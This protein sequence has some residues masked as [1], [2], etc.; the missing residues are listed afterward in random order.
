VTSVQAGYVGTDDAQ[1]AR[2]E[3]LAERLGQGRLTAELVYARWGA[4][5]QRTQLDLAAPLIGRLAELAEG[6]DPVVELYAEH[7]RGIDEWDRGRMDTAR[8]AL[9]RAA[10]LLAALDADQSAATTVAHDVRQLNPAFRGMLHA[11]TG[12]VEDG[13]RIL[14]ELGRSVRG[15]A[16]RTIVWAHFS[17]NTASLLGDAARTARVAQEGLAADPDGAFAFIGTMLR[18][19][20][21]WAEGMLGSAEDAAA[22][23]ARIDDLDRRMQQLGATSGHHGALI[24]SADLHLAAGDPDGADRALDAAELA[25]AEWGQRTY[26]PLIGVLRARVL[27]ARGAPPERVRAALDG[28]R[29]TARERG[30]LLYVRRADEVEAALH[31]AAG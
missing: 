5:S 9:D 7:A 12:D 13:W 15:D 27:L 10:E 22:A 8:R 19:E 2:G 23:L 6:G 4:A 18:R 21:C 30:A 29:A 28:A 16:Y 17:A 14:A 25:V 20:Q 11:L 26:E 1:L 3:A 24:M 31:P